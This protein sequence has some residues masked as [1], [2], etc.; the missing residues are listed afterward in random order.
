M[1]LIIMST[2]YVI[3]ILVY[4]YAVST[5]PYSILLLQVTFA[6][7]NTE[8]IS[9]SQNVDMFQYLALF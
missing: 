6:M 3:T 4:S 2:F 7:Y 5:L 9:C 8:P 1:Q